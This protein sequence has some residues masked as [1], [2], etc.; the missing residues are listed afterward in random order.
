LRALFFPDPDGTTVE[1]IEQPPVGNT[2]DP[3]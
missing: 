2:A 1:L 3:G